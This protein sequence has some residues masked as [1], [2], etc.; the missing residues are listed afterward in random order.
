ML[1]AVPPAYAK[2][3]QSK[4]C[5]GA[6]GAEGPVAFEE[7]AKEVVRARVGTAAPAVQQGY[8]HDS[9]PERY[10]GTS[11]TIEIS[12]AF[13]ISGM[14]SPSSNK[15]FVASTAK[16]VAPAWRIV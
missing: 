16:Q 2:A 3:A 13:A 1:Q 4:G 10:Y 12:K 11:A 8:S 5:R 15:H 9:K 6:G 7:A 14:A